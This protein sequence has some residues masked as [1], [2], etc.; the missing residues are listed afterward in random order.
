MWG[1]PGLRKPS[2]RALNRIKGTMVKPARP[3][4]R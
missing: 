2:S 1:S 4:H 3:H